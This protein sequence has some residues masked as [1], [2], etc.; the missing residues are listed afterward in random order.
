MMF[1]DDKAQELVFESQ[2]KIAI[3]YTWFTNL[4]TASSKSNKARNHDVA[5]HAEGGGGQDQG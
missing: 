3:R 5:R 4:Y 2:F 1:N